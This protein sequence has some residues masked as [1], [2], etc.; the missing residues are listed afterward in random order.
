MCIR[1]S[2]SAGNANNDKRRSASRPQSQ[3]KN[4]KGNA[5]ANTNHSKAPQS[6]K[7]E[8]SKMGTLGA[9]LQEAGVTK[10]K[11]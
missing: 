3:D 5:G 11:R 2:P 8:P 10:A 6:N 4:D 1:D 7:P 9:L